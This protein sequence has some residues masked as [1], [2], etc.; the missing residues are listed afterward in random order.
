VPNLE[1]HLEAFVVGALTMI[2]VWALIEFESVGGWPNRMTEHSR[3]GSWDSWG[4]WILLT[5]GSIVALHAVVTY[6]LPAS[7]SDERFASNQSRP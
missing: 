2:A 3:F 1:L 7:T 6:V 4:L 5:W